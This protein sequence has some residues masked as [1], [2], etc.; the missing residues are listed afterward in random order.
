MN[1]FVDGDTNKKEKV[2]HSTFWRPPGKCS[3][4]SS[5]SFTTRPVFTTVSTDNKDLH[6]IFHKLL[7]LPDKFVEKYGKKANARCVSPKFSPQKDHAFVGGRW[8]PIL[9]ILKK[10]DMTSRCCELKLRSNFWKCFFCAKKIVIFQK[11]LNVVFSKLY[12]IKYQK[13]SYW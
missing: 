10:Y 8:Q 3:I 6:L 9:P 1:S 4:F 2:P 7:K 11:D 5:F 13:R 12:R